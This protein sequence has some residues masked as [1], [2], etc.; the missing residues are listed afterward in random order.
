M[1]ALPHSATR[2]RGGGIY[3]L[4]CAGLLEDGPG[5]AGRFDAVESR[6]LRTRTIRLIA[7]SA[8]TG[9][10]RSQANLRHPQ[11]IRGIIFFNSVPNVLWSDVPVGL[12]PIRTELHLRVQMSPRSEPKDSI[13]FSTCCSAFSRASFCSS[14]KL[15]QLNNA[16]FGTC[17]CTAFHMSRS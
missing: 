2:G 4:G 9:T 7:W 14:D 3:S 8:V 1:D 6:L 13:S 12:S 17:C 5:N 10:C 11:V 16:Q 15:S